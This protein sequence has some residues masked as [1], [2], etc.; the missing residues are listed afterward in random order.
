MSSLVN[1]QNDERLAEIARTI[2]LSG[3]TT[4]EPLVDPDRDDGTVLDD[5]DLH[6]AVVTHANGA[7][8]VVFRSVKEDRITM[9]WEDEPD[10][11]DS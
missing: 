8:Y 3:V 11:Q 10:E 6:V 1:S 4:W 5:G 2:D 7:D 9:L